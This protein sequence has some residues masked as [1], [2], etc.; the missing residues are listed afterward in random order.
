VS[1]YTELGSD[2]AFTL[3]LATRNRSKV[4]AESHPRMTADEG[5][6]LR[7]HRAAIPK[8]APVPRPVPQS[9]TNRQIEIAFAALAEREHNNNAA[10]VA[11]KSFK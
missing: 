6:I 10:S 1:T 5:K 4:L 11:G 9:F 7:F 2:A 3:W 8:P